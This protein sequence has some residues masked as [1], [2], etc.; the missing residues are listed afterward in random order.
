M[1]KK[2]EHGNTG[3]QYAVKPA[4]TQKTSHLALR[5]HQH[6]RDFFEE[7]AAAQGVRLTNWVEQ[8]LRETA[9]R[10]LGKPTP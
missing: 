3:N 5:I 6:D 7:A 8:S 4:G 1:S 2:P 10:E 9:S